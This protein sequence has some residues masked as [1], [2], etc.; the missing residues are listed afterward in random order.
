MISVLA[1]R[2]PKRATLRCGCRVSAL[3]RDDGRVCGGHAP[4][5]SRMAWASKVDVDL[6]A[7][8]AIYARRLT[9][10]QRAPR[11][12]NG[13]RRCVALHRVRISG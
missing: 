4:I 12:T 1:R 8:L 2:L 13:W 6:D 9:A 5:A 10:E 3:V 11:T 7:G